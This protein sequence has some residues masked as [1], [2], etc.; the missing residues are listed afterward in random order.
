MPHPNWKDHLQKLCFSQG[1]DHFD[2][3]VPWRWNDQILISGL[4][5]VHSIHLQLIIN[6]K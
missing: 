4:A 2:E 3:V 1:T 5:P 6:K